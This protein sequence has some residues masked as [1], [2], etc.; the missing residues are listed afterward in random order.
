MVSNFSAAQ[1]EGLRKVPRDRILVET[2]SPYF[3]KDDVN[4]PAYIGDVAKVVA[5]PSRYPS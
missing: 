3:G 4:T 1:L 5:D 2:D